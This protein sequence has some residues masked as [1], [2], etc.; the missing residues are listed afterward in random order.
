L[1]QASSIPVASLLSVLFSPMLYY[2]PWILGSVSL[3]RTVPGIAVDVSAVD[4]IAAL[5]NSAGSG[6][7]KVLHQFLQPA[8]LEHLRNIEEKVGGGIFSLSC[9]HWCKPDVA[10]LR[11]GLAETLKLDPRQLGDVRLGHVSS[12]RTRQSEAAV[13]VVYIDASAPTATEAMWVNAD[14]SSA[15]LMWPDK[16][17]LH[18][19]AVVMPAASTVDFASPIE[20]ALISVLHHPRAAW[21]YYVSGWIWRYLVSDEYVGNA[22]DVSFFRAHT[23]YPL[24]WHA[25]VWS[26][27]GSFV[28]MASLCVP[29]LLRFSSPIPD[30]VKALE[31]RLEKRRCA[32]KPRPVAK[33]LPTIHARTRRNLA[34]NFDC[35]DCSPC[36]PNTQLKHL[37]FMA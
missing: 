30:L 36:T 3:L 23:K 25:C 7:F 8:T 26:A 31:Q 32:S 4:A 2:L 20:V 15:N 1:A 34:L 37:S 19:S 10:S 22:L 11:E 17:T 12:V 33:K 14:S 6:S 9:G 21:E 18:G 16:D 35:P 28:I 5:S 13:I 29:C 27:I 24:F